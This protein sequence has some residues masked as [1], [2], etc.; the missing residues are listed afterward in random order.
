MLQ[1]LALAAVCAAVLVAP[2]DLSAQRVSRSRAAAAQ[3]RPIAQASY[4]PLAVGNT[5]TYIQEGRAAGQPVTIQVR[6]SREINGLTYYDVE[7]LV[8]GRA[9]L[10]FDGRGRLVEYREDDRSEM[11]W[12]DFGAPVGGSWTIDRPDLCFAKAT[13]ASRTETVK[14]PAGVFNNAL[15]VDFGPEANCADAGLDHDLFVPGVG[16]VERSGITI[17]GPLTWRLQE[18]RVNGKTVRASGA[19]F[20]ATTD[21]LTYVP[22]FFPVIGEKEDP[23]PTVRVSLTLENTTGGPLTLTFNSGQRFDVVIRDDAGEIVW[24][25]SADKAF[26]AVVEQVDFEGLKTWVVEK[27]L[28][29]DDRPWAA[30]VYTVEAQLTNAGPR[31]YSAVTSFELTEPVF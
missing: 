3:L 15:L 17:A 18:A 2:C 21:R 4:L 24:T 7:G 22:D 9:L 27:R 8:A 14:T 31:R 6:D 28:G 16:L 11:L 5:W 12:Y 13:V 10:R 20:S 1:R 26:P 25:W 19:G 30:G 29:E 23:I